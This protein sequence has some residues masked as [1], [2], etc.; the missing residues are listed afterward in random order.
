MILTSN[1]SSLYIKEIP[2][3]PRKLSEKVFLF[4]K[5]IRIPTSKRPLTYRILSLRQGDTLSKIKITN[6]SAPED[7]TIDLSVQQKR[8]EQL[9]DDSYIIKSLPIKEINNKEFTTN[10]KLD[11]TKFIQISYTNLHDRGYIEVSGEYLRLSY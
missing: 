3:I 9:N 10:L 4:K 5:R 7:I 2:P 6:T 8:N 1:F 11:C